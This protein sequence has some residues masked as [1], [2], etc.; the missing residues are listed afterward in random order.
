[1]TDNFSTA[2]SLWTTF[3][4][5]VTARLAVNLPG[6]Q[7]NVAALI[8]VLLAVISAVLLFIDPIL[9]DQ[10][11]HNFADKRQGANIPNILN[12]TSNLPF[13]VV[14]VYGL[15]YCIANPQPHAHHSWIAFF[16][17]VTL[18]CAGSAYYHWAPNDATL[19]WD[20][21]PMTIAFMA[22]FTALLSEHIHAT[23]DNHLL[24]PALLVGIASV[25]YWRLS[26]DLRVYGLVQFFPLVAIPLVVIGLPDRYSHEHLLGYGLVF[27]I[28]AK[29]C[30]FYDTEIFTNLGIS[31]HSIKHLLAA[32]STAAVLVMLML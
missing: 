15:T 13:A 2:K 1:M 18:I 5:P 30:E 10:A 29:I 28:V 19:F 3:T 11:Y 8:I 22:L 23:F 4:Q 20:R 12:V 17:G 25:L 6:R 14:G 31:G 7:G 32:C 16:A 27:Y 21:L 24:L 9:Q 26:G